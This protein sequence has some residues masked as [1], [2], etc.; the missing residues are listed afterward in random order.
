MSNLNILILAFLS[1]LATYVG[2]LIGII[3]KKNNNIAF[4]T[5]FAAGIMLLISFFELIPE[6]YKSI[7]NYF[8]LFWVLFGIGIIWLV[9]NI[10]PHIHTIKEIKNCDKKCSIRIAYLIVIGLILHDFPEGFAIP[11]SFSTSTDLGFLLVMAT[12][13]HNIPEGYV[14]T[15]V[16]DKKN[17]GFFYKS[18]IFSAISTLSGA[19]IGIILIHWFSFM[20]P[21]FLS[22]ASGAMIFISIHELIPLSL[23][24]NQKLNF[25]YGTLS[26]IITYLILII[27]F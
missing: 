16:S 2:V 15:V 6:A 10:L 22:I 14:L 9:N 24:N 11:S 1:G 8:V 21:I 17:N 27:I 4:G 12:F 13:I 7:N 3:S 25:F 20:N 23:K 26:S 5:S 19:T 18:A